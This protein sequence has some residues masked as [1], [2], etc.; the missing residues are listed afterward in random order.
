MLRYV[1]EI[2]EKLYEQ[3][4][5]V[6][7]LTKRS[8]LNFLHVDESFVEKYKYV[9]KESG[10]R[11]CLEEIEKRLMKYPPFMIRWIKEWMPLYILIAKSLDGYGWYATRNVG[12]VVDH[13]ALAYDDVFH[14]D[15]NDDALEHELFHHFDEMDTMV[16][17]DEPWAKLHKT[18]WYTYD[19]EKWRDMVGHAGGREH[20]SHANI[21]EDQ[22]TMWEVVYFPTMKYVSTIL[23]KRLEGRVIVADKLRLITWCDFVI[24]W[25]TIKFTGMLVDM[26]RYQLW[27]WKKTWE[28][29]GY[30]ESQYYAKRSIDPISKKVLMNEH[31]W[32]AVLEWKSIFWIK[33]TDGSYSFSTN[34]EV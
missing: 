16:G 6:E 30:S 2:Q 32:N 29:Y 19:L 5:N 12:G 13:I 20:Y 18:G 15:S 33:N 8:D 24:K 25:R 14:G 9:F 3:W 23:A 26:K 27:M 1:K 22:A 11:K 17:D 21:H 28:K 10:L 34:I 4:Y 31:F 7:F